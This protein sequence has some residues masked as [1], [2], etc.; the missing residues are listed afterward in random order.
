MEEKVIGNQSKYL[1]L[2]CTYICT[3]GY[4]TDIYYLISKSNYYEVYKKLF[5][6][7][8]AALTFYDE[9]NSKISITH[10]T[11]CTI[12]HMCFKYLVIHSMKF[13]ILN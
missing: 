6:I 10:S 13:P 3:Y 12:H 2:W 4:A 8:L 11:K 9:A 5:L 1:T 7:V